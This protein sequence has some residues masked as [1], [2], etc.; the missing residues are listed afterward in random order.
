M[1]KK[2]ERKDKKKFWKT[3]LAILISPRDGLLFFDV[4]QNRWRHFCKTLVWEMRARNKTM[5]TVRH[6]NELWWK[7]HPSTGVYI[8]KALPPTRGLCRGW[9]SGRRAVASICRHGNS[10][11]PVPRLL[12]VCEGIMS[13]GLQPKLF[14]VPTLL[15]PPIGSAFYFRSNRVRA[16]PPK[17]KLDNQNADGGASHPRL[18]FF[19][20]LSY[21]YDH[22]IL[23]LSGRIV[24]FQTNN[25]RGSSTRRPVWSL[26]F[27]R[28]LFGLLPTTKVC[29]TCGDPPISFCL[30]CRQK[31]FLFAIGIQQNRRIR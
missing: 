16:K 6:E 14:H 31:I 17:L 24:T 25:R 12:F 11:P 21:F 29:V 23:F 1:T 5:R 27:P 18:L 2:N 15:A 4:A 8:G 22:E 10:E 20:S 28:N 26:S 9:Q 19:F 30:S 7:R 3:H 13:I